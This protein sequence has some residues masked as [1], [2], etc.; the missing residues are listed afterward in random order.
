MKFN[1]LIYCFYLSSSYFVLAA[2]TTT[3]NAVTTAIANTNTDTD[4]TTALTATTATTP[5]TTT[6]TAATANAVTTA[7]AS[8]TSNTLTTST[9]PLTTGTTKTTK[10]TTKKHKTTSSDFTVVWLTHTIKGVTTTVS[11]H[12]IQSFS[13]MYTAVST[14]PAGTI[15][16]GTLSGTVGTT[17][18][19][20]YE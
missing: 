15:G 2:I 14:V 8:T 20:R 11:S 9:T 3:D 13:S 16:L 7:V 18:T 4:T 10:R 1:F 19:Y 17:R 5:T 6:N 12:W